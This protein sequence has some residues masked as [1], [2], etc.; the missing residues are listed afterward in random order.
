[1]RVLVEAIKSHQASKLSPGTGPGDAG[2]RYPECQS[3]TMANG[4]TSLSKGA[5]FD[6]GMCFSC[7]EGGCS[8]PLPIMI[9]AFLPSAFC[10]IFHL[11]LL[12]SSQEFLG[13]PLFWASSMWLQSQQ[14]NSAL[15]LLMSIKQGLEE[16]CLLAGSNTESCR[17]VSV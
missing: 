8:C 13:F 4:R 14:R 16:T 5:F 1:M 17:T 7:G 3:S 9:N 6:P 15:L 10:H 12:P 11:G 2:V